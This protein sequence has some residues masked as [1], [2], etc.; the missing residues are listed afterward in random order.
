MNLN[1]QEK[2][3]V[4]QWLI[5]G[6]FTL[7][8]IL[9]IRQNLI[10]KKSPLPPVIEN[11]TYYQ[12]LDFE[13]QM[14]NQFLFKAFPYKIKPI[15]FFNYEKSKIEDVKGYVIIIF[16]LTVCGICLDSEMKVLESYNNILKARKISLLSIIGISSKS[17]ISEIASRYKTGRISFPFKFI[18]VEN[19]Y[20]TFHLTRD[21]Y[22]DTPFYIYASPTFK[23][24]NVLKSQYMDT[25]RL[26]KWI[27]LI[28][29]QEVF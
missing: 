11:S 16:D 9:L 18:N 29:D 21:K 4:S 10:L 27:E 3:V 25:R 22:L 19:L 2:I 15:D 26:E 8:I 6:V 17:E 24:C 14:N 1:K 13:A 5:I 23:V 12:S 20:N 7:L 28:I